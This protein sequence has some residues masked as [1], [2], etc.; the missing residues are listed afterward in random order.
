MAMNGHPPAVFGGWVFLQGSSR[1]SQFVD[2]ALRHVLP[3]RSISGTLAVVRQL[4][5]WGG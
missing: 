4:T 2:V 1:Q 3:T 5:F